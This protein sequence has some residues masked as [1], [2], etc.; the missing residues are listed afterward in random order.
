MQC[1]GDFMVTC[2]IPSVRTSGLCWNIVRCIYL[3]HPES[4]TRVWNLSHFTT[5]NEPGGWKIET[6]NKRQIMVNNIHKPPSNNKNKVDSTRKTSM[7]KDGL[8]KLRSPPLC[9]LKTAKHNMWLGVKGL[10]SLQSR[11]ARM[12]HHEYDALEG[13][14]FFWGGLI[15]LQCFVHVKK[16]FSNPSL[17]SY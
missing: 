11:L 8:K 1:N 13:Y 14:R 5:N 3:N 9:W 4:C 15:V 7:A 6:P 16:S 17:L 12:L 10:G 2:S